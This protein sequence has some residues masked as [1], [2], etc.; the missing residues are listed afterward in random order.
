MSRSDA[1]SARLGSRTPMVDRVC[2]LRAI[3]KSTR[4]ECADY[5]IH[6]PAPLLIIGPMAI[7]LHLSWRFGQL[8][9]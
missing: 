7:L 9:G 4:E 1:P 3:T 6:G 2:V 8:L 5:Y